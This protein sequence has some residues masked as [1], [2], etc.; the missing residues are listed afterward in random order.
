M[1]R[2][3]TCN[4]TFTD[5][6]LSFCIDDGTPL[7]PV[8]LE[9]N[10]S[11]R[12]DDRADWKAAYQ[13]P[14]SYVPPGGNSKRRVWPWVLG[15]VGVLV[16][17]VVG[18]SIAAALWLPGLLRNSAGQN[19]EASNTRPDDIK[20]NVNG[21]PSTNQN[22]NPAHNN[23]NGAATNSNNNSSNN[24]NIIA[25][26]DQ[27]MVLVQLTDLEHEWTVANLNADKKKLGEILA[28]DYVGPTAEGS[29]QGKAEYI[30][31]IQRDTTVENWEFQDLKLTLRGDRATLKGKLRL[32]IQ[33]RDS[34]YDF[35]DKFVW[36]DGRWQATGSEVTPQ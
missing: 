16:I 31:N 22:S 28:D 8:S 32:R 14:G 11:N 15:I 35:V 5:Q 29:F 2:C 33:D 3:P 27:E 18:L 36:R 4:K 30:R 6:T 9:D 20:P 12:S 24:E 26:T 13:P 17:G 10:S 23:S 25:P 7:I 19:H 34:V 21:N 1:K